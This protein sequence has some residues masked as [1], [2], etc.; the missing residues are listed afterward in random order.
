VTDQAL[1]ALDTSMAVPL[2]ME[3]HPAHPMVVAWAQGRQLALCGHALAV[4]AD[5]NRPNRDPRTSPG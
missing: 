2:V 4:V 1:F 3:S 5:G